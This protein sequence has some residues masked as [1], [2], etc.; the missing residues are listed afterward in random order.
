DNSTH[1]THL[2]F[3]IPPGT[4]PQEVQR[5]VTTEMAKQAREHRTRQRSQMEN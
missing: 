3:P 4:S 5:L 1:E 2:V